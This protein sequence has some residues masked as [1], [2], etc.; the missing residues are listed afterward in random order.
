MKIT[1][2]QLRKL[3]RESASVGRISSVARKAD[4]LLAHVLLEQDDELMSTAE[5]TAEDQEEED[6]QK[7]DAARRFVQEAGSILS[8]AGSSLV[9]QLEAA[10]TDEASQ[11]MGFKDIPPRQV[12]EKLLSSWASVVVDQGVDAADQGISDT[13][14]DLATKAMGK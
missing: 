8:T 9:D 6:R 3:I 7:T 1:K 4:R 14:E 10:V 12:A 5:D 11:A 13:L 2:R